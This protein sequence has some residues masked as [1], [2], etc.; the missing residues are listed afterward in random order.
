MA[1]RGAGKESE[2]NGGETVEEATGLDKKK[3]KEKDVEELPTVSEV[4]QT[5]TKE[6]IRAR[7]QDKRYAKEGRVETL[8]RCDPRSRGVLRELGVKEGVR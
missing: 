4:R 3:R 5:F 1:V 8:M 7:L 2:E 6:E